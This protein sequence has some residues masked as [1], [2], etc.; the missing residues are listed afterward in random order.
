MAPQNRAEPGRAG[1]DRANRRIDGLLTKLAV[2][3]LLFFRSE[4][5]LLSGED[6][7]LVRKTVPK[8]VRHLADTFSAKIGPSPVLLERSYCQR[9]EKGRF[10]SDL[11]QDLFLLPRPFSKAPTRISGFGGTC[12]QTSWRYRVL[13]FWC[14]KRSLKQCDIWRILFRPRLALLLCF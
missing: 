5:A 4:L 8:A 10:S 7:I 11:F 3:I 1:Q 2:Q 14:E 12:L 9:A 6:A 13:W